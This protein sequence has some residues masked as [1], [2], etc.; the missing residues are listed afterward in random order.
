MPININEVS[1][2]FSCFKIKEKENI[3]SLLGFTNAKEIQKD[4][5]IY[6]NNNFIYM[7]KNVEI[8]NKNNNSNSSNY[9][10]RIGNKYNILDLKNFNFDDESYQGFIICNLEFEDISGKIYTKEIYFIQEIGFNFFQIFMKKLIYFGLYKLNDDEEDD[11]NIINNNNENNFIDNNED[12]NDENNESEEENENENKN[13]M[14]NLID[15]V[16]DSNKLSENINAI[17]N[18]EKKVKKKKKK[19]KDKNEENEKEENKIEEN[20]LK[21]KNKKIFEEGEILDIGSEKKHKKKK[22]KQ[23]IE[24]DENNE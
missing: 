22:K 10:R 20:V 19:K 11:E 21:N 15:D 7:I 17:I 1:N 2:I 16:Y 3:F 24:K 8:N 4:Y 13:Q 6:L 5:F 23:K 18:E 9:I 12:L 14:N